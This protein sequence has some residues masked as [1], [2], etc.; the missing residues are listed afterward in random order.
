MKRIGNLYEKLC[1]PDNIRLAIKNASRHKSK[2]RNVAKVL[3]DP[4]GYC[5]RLR[6]M[7]V[8]KDI[9][10]GCKHLKTV[11]EDNSGKVRQITVPSF[12][13]DQILHW[14]VVQVLRP[15]L[16]R[17]MYEYSCGSIPGRGGMAAKK[18]VERILKNDKKVKYIA[19]LDV[20][21]FF[22][23][24]SADKLLSLFEKKIK[25]KDMLWVIEQ[26][27]IDGDGLPIGYY[28][29]QWFSNFY[30]QELDHFIK[31]KLKIRHYVRYADDMVLLD[32]NKRKLHKARLQIEQF[33][34][35][36][37]YKLSLKDNWQVWKVDSRPLDFVGYRFTRKGTE[38]REHIFF[39]L[40][41]I[42]RQIREKCLSIIRAR[43]YI[44]L[45]GWTK[46]IN[47]KKYYTEHIRPLVSQRTVKRYVSRWDRKNN[48]EAIVHAYY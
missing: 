43:R 24:V 23:S 6:Q 40:N 16:M 5:E 31:K 15:V 27:L 37:E 4:E 8:S 11:R 1:D 35:E 44:S 20:R 2:K 46:H 26:I 45:I 38:L 25:D 48:K 22:P 42:A 33:L 32:T 14:A 39:H 28:T 9:K 36:G 17:G 13:P 29:S 21:K 12:F 34:A 19:K 47:F 30:L 41:R 3:A 7:L 18:K 10:F